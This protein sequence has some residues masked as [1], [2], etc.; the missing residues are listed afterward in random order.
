VPLSSQV[1]H[2]SVDGS[3][4]VRVRHLPA[5]TDPTPRRNIV[6]FTAAELSQAAT[7]AI[8]RDMGIGDLLMLTP[9][10]RALKQRQPDLSIS[11]YCCEHLMCLFDG[12]PDLTSVHPLDTYGDEAPQYDLSVDLVG[13]VE[14]S[15]VR[16][17]LDRTS[18]FAKALDVALLDGFPSYLVTPAEAA[19]ASDFLKACPRPWVAV[20]P[21]AS[22]GRRCW[23]PD[24]LTD[25]C[26]RFYAT[27]G[28]LFPVHHNLDMDG[29]SCFVHK[30]CQ[31]LWQYD[32]R[33]LAAILAQMDCVVSVD[34][35]PYHLAASAGGYSRQPGLVVLFGMVNPRLRTHWY[36]QGRTEALWASQACERCPC[37]AALS[38]CPEAGAARFACMKAMTGELVMAAVEK[39]LA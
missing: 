24:N 35:G 29:A 13:W 36:N 22:E 8:R 2:T 38:F 39:H 18:V 33:L 10:L 20:A 32:L 30:R 37:D 17:C 7:L 9:T 15:P 3:G 31:P 28:T 14:R 25:F 26:K 1:K 6:A 16:D 5:H 11:L 27:G 34:S 19:A 21:L 12:S 4:H 23:I